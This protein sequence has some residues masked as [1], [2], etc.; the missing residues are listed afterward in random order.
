MK[1]SYAWLRSLL[2]DL[3]VPP[4]E[5]A[6]RLTNA[7]LEVEALVEYG[8][9][10]DACLVVRVDSVRPHPSKSGLRLVT[11]DRGGATQEIV[12][13][14]PNVPDPGGLVVLA[15]LGVT[16]P[17]KGLTIAPRAIGG[18]ASEGMLCSESELGLSDES[19]GILVLPAGLAKPGT[20]LSH[21]LPEARDT[22]LE[23][24][25]T[26]N[27]PDGL[28]HVGLAREIAALYKLLWVVPEIAPPN[29]L[30]DGGT[31]PTID[32][33]VE[34]PSRCSE[35]SAR[36]VT[37]IEIRPSPLAVRYRLSSLGIRPISN[38]VDVTNLVMLEFGHPM[39]AFDLDLVRGGRI[40]VRRAKDGEV[41]ETL[42]GEK[43][44][45]HADDLVI[46]D[47]EGPVAL[48]G[49]MGGASSEIRS[50]TTRVLFECATFDA[51]G[52]RRAARRHG[53]HTESSHR[54][55]RGIDPGDVASV[56]ARAVTLTTNLSPGA[57]AAPLPYGA[58]AP[59][60]PRKPIRLRRDRLNRL[61]GF[62]VD[63]DESLAILR[64]LGCVEGG[65]I[66]AE[67]AT[68]Y[69]PTH[70]PDLSRE[71]DLVDEVIRVHGVDTVPKI[72]PAIHPTRPVGS[73]E[74]LVR[75]ARSAAVSVGLSEAITLAFA[76]KA[77]HA[78]L[79]A[80][81][82]T[83]L[84]KN[85]LSQENEAM[86]T[87]LALGLIQS[88]S[89]AK[90][91]GEP[92]AR[93][94][95][96]GATFFAKENALPEERLQFAA[97]LS[98]DREGYLAKPAPV[99][100]WDGKG[101]ALEFVGRVTTTTATVTRTTEGP[102]YLHPRGAGRIEVGGK[103]VGFV[104]PLHPDV[105]ERFELDAAVLL[106]ID[107]PAL[108]TTREVRFTPLPRFPSSIRDVALVVSDDILAGE[109]ETAVREAAG[110][111]AEDV[112]L[113]DRF[114]G[115]SLPKDHA[116]LAFRIVYRAE[117]RTLTDAEVDVAHGRVLAV[118]EKRFG[119]TLRS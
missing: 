44:K 49:V 97:L 61:L 91:K 24:N 58:K 43:R 32:I 53:L 22:I 106:E 63:W 103:V 41:L 107:L 108:Q 25:L 77:D 104:G 79:G 72:L 15:P 23:I 26:A 68:F 30:V 76:S 98:G 31:P 10:S 13:G 12:C 29:E 5:L 113:F 18:V 38:V 118:V 94:F 89:A 69:A 73:R 114:V 40:Q 8:E 109:V 19:G 48:A 83:V 105:L 46:C 86:R 116:S 71:A 33:V 80:P 65:P 90:R 62:E 11:V 4:R 3:D 75:H 17:A 112:R 27:R 42:D 85:P 64:R 34:D 57:H 28:G 52:I 50:Q 6:S 74:A 101:L 39:H 102:P 81:E 88:A 47:G 9:A 7:G 110:V 84:V 14:A 54:F 96:I 60:A 56:L 92:N 66:D 111:L 95:T 59:A 1:A 117:D 35:Y 37:E 20:V 55:E 2:P 100:A 36:V 51:R 82:P 45:L 67:V 21:A 93:L 16:L 87:T 78:K 99:D 115:A 119:A 70:R